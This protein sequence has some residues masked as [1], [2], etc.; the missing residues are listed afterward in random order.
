MSGLW[1]YG[2]DIMKKLKD[3]VM[4]IFVLLAVCGFVV[5]LAYVGIH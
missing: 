5:L 4:G 2:G 3:D 1:F